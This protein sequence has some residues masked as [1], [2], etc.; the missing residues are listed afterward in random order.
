M[1]AASA[2][3]CTACFTLASQAVASDFQNLD[4]EATR[5]QGIATLPPD[6][7]SNPDIFE[8]AIVTPGWSYRAEFLDGSSVDPPCDYDCDPPY[9]VHG[10]MIDGHIGLS[11]QVILSVRGRE[12]GRLGTSLQGRHSL[13]LE[14]GVQPFRRDAPD[15][16]LPV[17]YQ[18]GRVPDD[19]KSLLMLTPRRVSADRFSVRLNG[20]PVEMQPVDPGL[21]GVSQVSSSEVDEILASLPSD[22]AEI[23]ALFGVELFRVPIS[24]EAVL[25]AGNISSVAGLTRELAIRPEAYMRTDFTSSGQVS[26]LSPGSVTIDRLAFSSIA[27]LGPPVEVPEPL[28]VALLMTALLGAVSNRR[29]A[30]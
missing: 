28:G 18:M 7:Y 23:N 21:Y 16:P 5:L 17:A 15:Y 30:Q 9:P 14:S 4:F 6:S 2:F 10:G 29:R 27:S 19:A 25:Y 11:S 26:Y 22:F 8:P 20:Y 13:Y 12:G 24:D 1:R 3:L